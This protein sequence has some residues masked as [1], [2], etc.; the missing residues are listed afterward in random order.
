[1]LVI[2]IRQTLLGFVPALRGNY[3]MDM[4]SAP[5]V[6]LGKEW[7]GNQTKEGST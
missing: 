1:M 3:I 2:I 4:F 7:P 6:G 5:D